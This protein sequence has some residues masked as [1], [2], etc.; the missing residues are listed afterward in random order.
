MPNPAT[1]EEDLI[2][3]W[4]LG[5]SDGN[6]TLAD[7]LHAAKYKAGD[8]VLVDT[9]QAATLLGCLD[10]KHLH[11]SATALSTSTVRSY[12]CLVL[13][14]KTVVVEEVVTTST[15]VAAGDGVPHRRRPAAESV[16]TTCTTVTTSTSCRYGPLEGNP[17]HAE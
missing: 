2:R 6:V 10:T 15:I 11:I 1:G 4:Y 5:D 12:P 3:S 8:Y 9:D 7:C 17:A 14:P 16:I 13:K